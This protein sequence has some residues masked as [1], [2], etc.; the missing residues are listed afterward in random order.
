MMETS[1]CLIYSLTYNFTAKINYLQIQ[2]G[3][4]YEIKLENICHNYLPCLS[5]DYAPNIHLL[6]PTFI[7]HTII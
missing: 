1:A 3:F 2:L 7:G 5:T 6:P 4:S